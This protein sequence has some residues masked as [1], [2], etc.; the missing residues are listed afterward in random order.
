MTQQTKR[1]F[2]TTALLLGVLAARAQTAATIV[3]QWRDEQKPER[4]REFYQDK[5][6]L[7]Y[8]KVINSQSKDML[9]GQLLVKKMKYDD[10]T[11]TFT[12]MMSPPNAKLELDATITVLSNDKLRIVAKKLLI[13][14]TI[15]LVRLKQKEN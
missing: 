8:S 11:K 12:G 1:I 13:S 4:Q 7:Y 2:F 9:N 6:G 14:K 5:D 10:A 15:Y 3:G